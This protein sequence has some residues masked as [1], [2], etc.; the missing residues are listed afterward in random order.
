LENDPY[1]GL[2]KDNFEMVKKILL[3]AIEIKPSPSPDLI[4]D[5]D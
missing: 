5:E 4:A 2:N 1:A 3:H